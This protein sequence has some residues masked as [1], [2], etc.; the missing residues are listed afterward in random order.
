M[1]RGVD[2]IVAMLA[3]L[4]AGG[5]YVPLDPGV[6]PERLRYMLD[7]SDPTV[8]LTSRALRG[9]LGALPAG[10]RTID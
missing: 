2:L 3:T 1:E 7:D 9:Q 6:P 8:V 10:L 5:A 4:K